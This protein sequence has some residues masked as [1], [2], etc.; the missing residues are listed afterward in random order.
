MRCKLLCLRVL[1]LLLTSVLMFAASSEL[2]AGQQVTV[3]WDPSPDND[4]AAYV[5]YVEQADGAAVQR[6]QVENSTSAT[7]NGLTLGVP[8]R[9]YASAVD[10]LGLEGQYSPALTYTP[11]PV[12][13]ANVMVNGNF[14]S[15]YDGWSQSG[16][17]EVQSSVGT[18]GPSAVCFNAQ[19]MPANGTLAQSFDT[20]PGQ[21][22]SFSFDY[23]LYSPNGANQQQLL[24]TV[25]GQSTIMSQTITA[26]GSGPSIQYRSRY[27]AFTADSV[28]TTVSFQDVSPA[29]MGVDSYLDNVRVSARQ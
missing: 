28:Q 22:Y 20:L 23:G 19:D 10:T 26:T 17:Q 12:P 18:S 2:K 14:E 4:I 27:F 11:L 13:G 6:V 21:S 5:L 29:T 7:V 1:S 16:H 3:A 15:G 9:I 8:Y 25:Q 24:V